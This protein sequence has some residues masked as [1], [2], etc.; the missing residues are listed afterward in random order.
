MCL[1]HCGLVICPTQYPLY[2]YMESR[3]RGEAEAGISVGNRC[4]RAISVNR[5]HYR[6]VYECT[7]DQCRNLSTALLPKKP[8]TA[9]VVVIML[10][11]KTF[12]LYN[13]KEMKIQSATPPKKNPE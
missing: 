4:K 8:R 11:I 9:L 7:A 3:E 6:K 10:T 12:F 1:F 13:L 2:L 5:V